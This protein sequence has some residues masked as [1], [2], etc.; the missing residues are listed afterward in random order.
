M[1]DDRGLQP[2]NRRSYRI[3]GMRDRAATP[4]VMSGGHIDDLAP[5]YALGAL[6]PDEMLAVDAHLRSCHPCQEAVDDAQRTAGMLSYLAPPRIPSVDTKAALFARVAHAQRAASSAALPTQ[7]VEI[8]RTPTIPASTGLHDLVLP[9]QAVGAATTTP[10]PSRQSR[11]GWMMSLLSVPLLVALVATGF[12]GLQLR[13][14]LSTQSSQMAD[15]Q[16]EMAN[17]GAGTTTIQLSPGQAAPQAQGQIVL[18]ADQKSGVWQIDTNTKNGPVSYKMLAT[19]NGELV[20]IGQVTVDQEGQGQARIDLAQPFDSYENVRVQAQ[21]LN[22]SAPS[23]QLDTLV[24]D[25][26][27]ALGSTGS[28]MDVGP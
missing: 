18:G 7:S 27:G 21:P 3:A 17:F 9:S 25:T 15:L 5:A 11:S 20:E 4:T 19:Q 14:E 12:W 13:N 10:A 2:T 22:S 28:G 26:S 6:E 24:Q 1:S 16:S 23:D 8:F